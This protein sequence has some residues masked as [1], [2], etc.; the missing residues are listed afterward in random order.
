LTSAPVGAILGECN[1][2]ATVS[3]LIPLFLFILSLLEVQH[4]FHP[5]TTQTHFGL[6]FQN[7]LYIQQYKLATISQNGLTGKLFCRKLE[8]KDGPYITRLLPN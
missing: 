7:Y 4:S 5:A 8:N 6:T 2:N 1:Y 3:Q